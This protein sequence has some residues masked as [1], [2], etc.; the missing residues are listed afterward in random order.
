MRVP[1]VFVVL[2]FAAALFAAG[3]A[4]AQ[5]DG[6]SEGLEER[7]V[8]MTLPRGAEMRGLLSRRI[9]TRPDRVALLF[10]GSPGILRLREENG[11]PK[12]ELKGN[13][14]ARARRHLNDPAVMTVLVDC[15]TDHWTACDH[16]YR[17]SAQYAEDVGALVAGLDKEIGPAKFYVIG[18]SFGTLSSAHL[19]RR[20][21]PLLSGA[22]HTAT[23]AGPYRYVQNTAMTHFDWGQAKVPQ[24]FVHH[25][26]DPCPATPYRALKSAIGDL[27]L[28][29]VRGDKELEGSAC[30]AYS[31]HGFRGREREA[32][33]AIAAWIATGTVIPQIGEP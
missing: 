6:T 17:A 27:P 19:A 21:A 2:P 1:S 22:I 25:Q 5:R 8:A 33:R 18:T 3:E 26:D 10:V 7:I 30:E 9:G 15:P 24:L 4:G 13:F 31:Q 28:I 23:F 20:L 12:F 29:T 16:V 32:M 14:L 11:A